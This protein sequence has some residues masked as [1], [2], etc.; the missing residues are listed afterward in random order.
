[1][2]R[3]RFFSLLL[4]A[5]ALL[6]QAPTVDQV[7][8]KYYEAKGGLAKM[9]AVTTM[10][11]T[12]KM[13]GGPMEFPVVIEAKRPA[14]IRVDVNIQ[15]NQLIQAYDG[16]TGWSINP[17]QQS[18]K[19]DA[20]PMTPDEVREIEVQADMDG[21]LVDWQAK[22]HKVEFQGHEAVEGSDALKL[23]LTLKNGDT[24]T[25]YLDTDSYL[26]VKE[27]SKRK[28]RGTEFEAETT[29]GDYKEVGGLMIAHAM[30]SGA[31][32]M[33]QKQKIV[34]EKVE[35]NVPIADARFL[36]PAKQPAP[37]APKQEVP[38]AGPKK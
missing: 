17:F 33:P 35:L 15:G 19:K 16:K 6:A 31:K 3:T 25:I 20:E 37:E 28:V 10:R 23:K 7:L 36:M 13:S 14:S 27:A 12:A 38:A 9:K 32:G 4:A 5:P 2:I 29:L 1:M 18:A 24:R 34:I 22:G 21:P 8:A 30:E 11:I 26:E